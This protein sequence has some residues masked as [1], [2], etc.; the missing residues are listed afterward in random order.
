[1]KKFSILKVLGDKFCP[2]TA[3]GLPYPHLI[4]PWRARGRPRDATN[5]SATRPT[6]PPSITNST[7]QRANARRQIERPNR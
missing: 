3:Y 4:V 7:I 1:M 5:M 6:A 2:D